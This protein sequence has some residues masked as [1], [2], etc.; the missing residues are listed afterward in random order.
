MFYSSSLNYS[1][2]YTKKKKSEPKYFLQAE[3][4]V[5][6]K[7]TVGKGADI[8]DPNR[9]ASMDFFLHTPK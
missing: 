9:D 3:D 4:S 7:K 2:L 8:G 6:P 5:G 1:T